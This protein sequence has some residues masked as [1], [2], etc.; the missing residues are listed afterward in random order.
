MES[1]YIFDDVDAITKHT[2]A[3]MFLLE[4]IIHIVTH[5]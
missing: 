5:I 2:F 1:Y 4:I 3:T